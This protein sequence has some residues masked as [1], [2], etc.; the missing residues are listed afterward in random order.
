MVPPRQMLLA[1][2][3]P[4]GLIGNARN[5]GPAAGVFWF[6]RRGEEW[7]MG[8]ARTANQPLPAAK[9]PAEEKERRSEAENPHQFENQSVSVGLLGRGV[10]AGGA[11]TLVPR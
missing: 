11:S 1:R 7:G 10:A 2:G 4:F 3:F 8:S 5:R 6:D 9:V